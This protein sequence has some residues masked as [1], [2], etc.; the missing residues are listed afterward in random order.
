MPTKPRAPVPPPPFAAFRTAATAQRR[1][2]GPQARP[3]I[4][5]PP[6]P[7]ARPNS[8]VPAVWPGAPVPSP[9]AGVMQRQ[10]AAFAP[11]SVRPP[12]PSPRPVFPLW[13]AA[14]RRQP[15][16]PVP[17]NPSRVVQR[18]AAKEATATA[19]ATA[20]ASA[21]T[22]TATT[23]PLQDNDKKRDSL[24]LNRIY[25]FY[26][27]NGI[28]VALASSESTDKIAK[29]VYNLLGYEYNI[30]YLDAHLTSLE[31]LLNSGGGGKYSVQKQKQKKLQDHEKE[32]I[33]NFDLLDPDYYH[34]FNKNYE[35]SNKI[36]SRRRIVFNLQSQQDG[37]KL[38]NMFIRRFRSMPA[39]TAT[40]VA[41]AATAAAT[42]AGAAS[43]ASVNAPATTDFA[44]HIPEFKVYL[45]NIIH[46]QNT[47]L[48]FMRVEPIKLDKF[49]VYYDHVDG[50]KAD[51]VRDGIVAAV[52]ATGVKPGGSLAAFYATVASGIAWAEEPKYHSEMK[53]SFTESRAALIAAVVKANEKIA[54]F[55]TFVSLVMTQFFAKGVDMRQPHLH[56]RLS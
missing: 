44:R 8:A 47:A 22:A 41:P 28:R 36:G 35:K 13:A 3:V 4:P 29:V 24:A 51:W 45:G 34:V 12:A 50:P 19:T 14:A 32:A 56:F 20:G 49:V 6:I 43:A 25:N 54:D 23:S 52:Q 18:A 33:S 9:A 55:G 5:P 40:A 31:S 53:G 42:S 1:P 2:A 48:A 15:A 11:A 46:W 39:E 27:K 17:T 38:A 16:W 26:Y 37:L 30:Q 21:A 7:S 10:R